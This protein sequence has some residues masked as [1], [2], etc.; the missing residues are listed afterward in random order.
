[1]AANIQLDEGTSGKYAETEEVS[2]GVHRQTL[3]IAGVSACRLVSGGTISQNITCTA[4]NTDYTIT[5]ALNA[6]TKYV[7]I[8]CT[9]ACIVAMGAATSSTN[10]VYI[11]AGIP[12]VFPVTYTGVAATDRVHVQ[13]GTA[14]AVVRVTEMHD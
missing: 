7:V 1:M 11:G 8:Y 6:A 5:T 14:G 13:C 9:Y 4:S 10:G 2:S 3:K 12:S